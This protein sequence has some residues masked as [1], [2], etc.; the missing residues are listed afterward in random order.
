MAALSHTFPERLVEH[1][2][3]LVGHQPLERLAR[4]L[5]RIQVVV[6]TRCLSADRRSRSSASAGVF[7]SSV[8][9]GRKLRAAATGCNLVGAVHAEIG[10]FGEY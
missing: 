1:S 4:V 6:A 10:P 5:G 2:T 8:F 9:R 7:Q 3:P